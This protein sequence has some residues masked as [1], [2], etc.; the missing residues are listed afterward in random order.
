MAAYKDLAKVERDFR[1]IKAI[2]LDLRPIYHHLEDR[3]RAHVFICMLAGYLVWHLRQAWAP[4]TFTDENPTRAHRP[5]RP[6][7][8]LRR[9]PATKASRQQPPRTARP[10]TTFRRDL[11]HLATLTR[12]TTCSPGP[13]ID[14]LAAP[15]PLQ[16]RAFELIGAAIL[17]NPSSSQNNNPTN[18]ESPAQQ[19]VHSSSHVSSV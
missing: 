16:R 14:K 18:N 6:R 17:P 10:S 2:D 7:P 9:P 4:L 13:R 1:S 8:T 19:G 11:D 15:T 12:N 5:R 3:V